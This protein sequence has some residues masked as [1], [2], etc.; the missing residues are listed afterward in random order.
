MCQDV[1]GAAPSASP[2]SEGSSCQ[3]PLGQMDTLDSV[4]NVHQMKKLIHSVLS[5]PLVHQRLLCNGVSGF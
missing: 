5:Q 1:A 3:I 2:S 4:D